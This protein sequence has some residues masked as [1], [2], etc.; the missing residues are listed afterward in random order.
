MSAP[1]TA[2]VPGAGWDE[3][4]CTAALAR[5]EQLQAQVKILAYFSACHF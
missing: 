1:D 2:A 4:Q 3:A 5:L